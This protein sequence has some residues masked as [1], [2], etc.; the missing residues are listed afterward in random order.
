MGFMGKL[1]SG[2]T[3]YE[4]ILFSGE[5]TVAAA[6]RSYTFK[7][8]DFGNSLFTTQFQ[9]GFVV[10]INYNNQVESTDNSSNTNNRLERS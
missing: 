4:I 10:R 2:R 5:Q 3:N 7:N 8:V 6:K 9:K 1:G